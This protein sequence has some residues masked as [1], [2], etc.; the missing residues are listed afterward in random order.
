MSIKIFKPSNSQIEEKLRKK[1]YFWCIEAQ[2]PLLK[3]DWDKICFFYRAQVFI[4]QDFMKTISFHDISNHLMSL[5][6]KNWGKN[7]FFQ[8]HKSVLSFSN[9]HYWLY[10]KSFS[11]LQLHNLQRKVHGNFFLYRNTPPSQYQKQKK[12]R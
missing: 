6:K 9:E 11:N 3:P 1:W 2:N 12:I 4:Q 10:V 8:E 7:S 5:L